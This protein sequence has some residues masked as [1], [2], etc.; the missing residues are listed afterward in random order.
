MGSPTKSFTT[1]P[2]ASTAFSHPLAKPKRLTQRQRLVLFLRGRGKDGAT[3]TELI[4][5]GL[6]RYSSRLHECRAAQYTIETVHEEEGRYR[7]FLRRE[8]EVELWPYVFQNPDNSARPNL[9]PPAGVTPSLFAGV[10]GEG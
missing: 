3:N 9:E 10:A 8:P 1:H 4:G 5:L 7:Y 6:Y 2:R